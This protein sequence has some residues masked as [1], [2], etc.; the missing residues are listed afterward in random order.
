MDVC[1][2]P[3]FDGTSVVEIDTVQLETM[4]ESA[5]V[6]R[7]VDTMMCGAIRVLV[8][9]E[10]FLVQEQTPDNHLLV[11]EVSSLDEANHF[12]DDRIAAYER[13]WDG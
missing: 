3:R 2:L 8:T 13:M 9:N 4:L 5:R 7:E 10:K 12:V 1:Q 11:R 6:E